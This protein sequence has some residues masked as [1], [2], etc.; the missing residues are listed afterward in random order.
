MIAKRS[1]WLTDGPVPFRVL[2]EDIQEVE[3]AMV[4]GQRIVLQPNTFVCGAGGI[5]DIGITWGRRLMD[6]IYR[7]WSGE[8]SVLQEIVCEDRPARV[9]L[10]GHHLGRIVRMRVSPACGAICQRGAFIASTGKVDLGIAFT[11]RVRAGLFGG[12]G[13]VFQRV[14][15]EGDVF[16][17]ARGTVNDWI[18]PE[19]E[20]VR[21]STNNILAFDASVGYDVQF[22]GGALTLMFGGQGLFLSQLEGPGRVL[23]Q[24]IDHDAMVDQLARRRSRKTLRQPQTSG[25]S[26]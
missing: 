12:Q 7:K 23:T 4:P 6:P 10:G 22:S 11:G 16:L 1:D 15:G 3:F 8:A 18:V 20:I 19:S 5:R 2:G 9:I 13:V 25:E 21:V 14:T 26:K 17:H 24:S